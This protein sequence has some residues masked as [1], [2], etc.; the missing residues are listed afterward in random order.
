[1]DGLFVDSEPVWLTAETEIMQDFDYQWSTEDQN[2]CLG[3][4]LL[5]VGT[6]MYEKAGKVHSPEFFR[7]SLIELM[8][9]KLSAGVAVLPGALSLL[10]IFKSQGIPA[11][12]VSASPRILVDTV[13]NSIPEHSF[14]F[15]LSADDVENPKPNPECYIKAAH[16][17]KV[18]ISNCLVFEDSPTG[19]KAATSSGAS[20]IAIPHFVDIQPTNRLRVFS[21]LQDL[22]FNKLVS[23]YEQDKLV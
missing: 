11:A 1:M 5:R 14:L 20:V 12:L 22:D 23:I 7:D 3:G 6:Y 15:S 18:D 17:L 2:N 21:S 10:N 13:L 19:V 9:R 16:N 8:A 4:P